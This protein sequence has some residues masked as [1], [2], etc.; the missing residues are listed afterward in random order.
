MGSENDFV[1][2]TNID[3]KSNFAWAWWGDNARHPLSW[4][5]HFFDDMSWSWRR[6]MVLC[7]VYERQVEWFCRCVIVLESLLVFRCPRQF[8][9]NSSGCPWLD[10]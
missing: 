1:C 10:L 7:R 9:R 5:R 2:T 8:L 4:T 3:A 6:G